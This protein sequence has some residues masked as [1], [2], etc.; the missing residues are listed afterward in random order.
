M[1]LPNSISNLINQFSRLPGIGPKTAER[2]V[3]T[4]LRRPKTQIVALVEALTQFQGEIFLCRQCYNFTTSGHDSLCAIC[5][6]HKRDPALLCVVA[7]SLDLIAIE[8]AGFNGHYHIL[9]GMINP[10]RNI[11]PDELRAKEL[12]SRVRNNGVIEIILAFDPNQEGEFT[13]NYIKKALM[14]SGLK[15]TRL[16]RGLPQ[17]GDLDYADEITLSEALKGRREV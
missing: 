16:G 8:S 7:D 4:L 10:L 12:I 6:D 14:D 9:G 13:C 3:F 11:G 17:G 1:L 15:I 5:A 2:L